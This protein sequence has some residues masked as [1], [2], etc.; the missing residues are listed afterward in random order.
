MQFFLFLI[1][2]AE[3]K[4]TALLS[5]M[6]NRV[7]GSSSTAPISSANKVGFNWKVKLE[8]KTPFKVPL[9]C[10]T[11]RPATDCQAV[12]I[13]AIK[14]IEGNLRRGRLVN[15]KKTSVGL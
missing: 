5:A 3:G 10:T 4:V 9:S 8:P 12:E 1:K 6:L 14:M 7:T 2:S 15:F 13:A 11:R